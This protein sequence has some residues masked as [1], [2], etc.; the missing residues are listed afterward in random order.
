MISTLLK[1]GL[2]ILGLFGF[3]K[4]DPV[5]Q[6]E[7]FGKAETEAADEE[8]ELNDIKAASDASNNVANDSAAILLDPSNIGPAKPAQPD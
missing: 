7:R 3:G 5:A 2:W 6:G 4:Q 1:I 8:G